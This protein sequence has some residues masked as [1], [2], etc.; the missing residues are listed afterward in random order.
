MSILLSLARVFLG[1]AVL[2]MFLPVVFRC[3]TV[4][5]RHDDNYY[6]ER[7]SI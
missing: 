6:R 7:P 4:T 3:I 2:K 1:L 5:P